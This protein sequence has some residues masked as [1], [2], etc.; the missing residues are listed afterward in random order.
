MSQYVDRSCLLQYNCGNSLSVFSLIL[1]A[2][3]KGRRD[4]RNQDSI[5][6]EIARIPNLS[7][8]T[9]YPVI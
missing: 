8:F 7:V 5:G 2:D 4:D 9:R 3:N 1:L 6:R